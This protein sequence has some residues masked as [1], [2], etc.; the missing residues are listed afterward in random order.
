MAQLNGFG[1][2]S[3]GNPFAGAIGGY[4]AGGGSNPFADTSKTFDKG[5]YDQN[6]GQPALG[7]YAT[8]S[9]A[10]QPFQSWLTNTG[11]HRQLWSDYEGQFLAHNDPSFS[12]T[13]Y[14]GQNDP[15]ER[16]MQLS[17]AD[18][19]ETSQSALSPFAQLMNLG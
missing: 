5:L 7:Y 15:Y 9:G 2:G 1:G 11:T 12:F 14:L 10:N 17:S 3:Y 4:R 19:G 13:D 16:Y 8:Q 6:E 18:R